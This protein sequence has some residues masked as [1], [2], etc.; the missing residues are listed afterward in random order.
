MRQGRG[1]GLG[2]TA[3]A[4]LT[5][6]MKRVVRQQRLGYIA[7]VCPAHTPNL[8]PKGTTTVWD[9]DSLVFADICSPGTVENLRHNPAI[10]INVVDPLLRKGYRFK[11]S[12]VVL[13]AGSQFEEV[14]EFYRNIYK[15]HP[16]TADSVQHVVLVKVER[17]LPLISPIYSLGATEDEVVARYA[18][19]YDDLRPRKLGNVASSER[20]RQ[21]G[22]GRKSKAGTFHPKRWWNSQHTSRSRTSGAGSTTRSGSKRRV[23]ADYRDRRLPPPEVADCREGRRMSSET[24]EQAESR[25]LKVI[26]NAEHTV[27]PGF[28]AFEAMPNGL[29][30]TRSDAL[31][32]VRD[33]EFWSQLVPVSHPGTIK[34][35][36]KIFQF[37]FNPEFDATGFVGW[38]HS[39]LARTTGAASI[40]ICGKDRRGG[41]FGH[42]RGNIFDYWGCPS[43]L[44][45][46]VLAEVESLIE[47]G[48]T[49]G[50]SS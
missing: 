37:R 41:G 43:D 38:L 19:Y 7:T 45:G 20:S 27:L 24:P 40:V 48:R 25:L 4:I 2:C 42:G 23:S 5:P 13:A 50:G 9:D 3:V 35:L 22:G 1:T 32:C 10:E 11:G 26:A 17:V 15:M 39:R 28:Y 46:A 12:A 14:M 6:D 29:A 16:K 34:D 47:R 21:D 30:Q 44:V 18:K 8:S 36:F 49:S 33:G 31:A